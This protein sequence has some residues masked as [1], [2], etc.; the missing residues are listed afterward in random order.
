[1]V[2]IFNN[3]GSA[4]MI[5][6][7]APEC[8]V[9]MAGTSGGAVGHICGVHCG[10]TCLCPKATIINMKLFHSLSLFPSLSLGLW[11]HTAAESYIVLYVLKCCKC[12]E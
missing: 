12:Y 6:T 3:A 2:H 10:T 9:N 8:A 11:E 5:Q 4:D 1:M 7:H